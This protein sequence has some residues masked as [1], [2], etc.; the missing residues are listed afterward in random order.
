MGSSTQLWSSLIRYT[1][2]ASQIGFSIAIPLVIL[3]LTGRFLDRRFDSSPWFFLA[4]LL[5]SFLVSAVI[6]YRHVRRIL[7]LFSNMD[8]DAHNA[9]QDA[10]KKAKENE[11]HLT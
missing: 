1:V 7:K 11:E 6:M 10:Q 9:Q 2:L 4:S 5:L 8:H 3:A